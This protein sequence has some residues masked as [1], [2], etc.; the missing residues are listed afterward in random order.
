MTKLIGY[1]ALAI[2]AGAASFAATPD[3]IT[4]Q[5]EPVAQQPTVPEPVRVAPFTKTNRGLCQP[6]VPVP[7]AKP[8]P[9]VATQCL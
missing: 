4:P 3:D 7:Q 9:E 5:R 8:D 6:L 2:F 1:A